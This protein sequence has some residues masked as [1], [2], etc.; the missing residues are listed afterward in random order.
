MRR[1]SFLD[2]SGPK[3][4]RAGDAGVKR[5]IGVRGRERPPGG[6]GPGSVMGGGGGRIRAG[7]R[8]PAATA[9]R[10][11]LLPAAFLILSAALLAGCAAAPYAHA[12]SRQLTVEISNGAFAATD[13]TSVPFGLEFGEAINASTLDASDINASSGTVRNLRFSPQYDAALGSPAPDGRAFQSPRNVAVDGSGNVYVVSAGISRVR[14]VDSA[15][16]H[17]ADLPG[18]FGRPYDVAVDRTSGTAYVTDTGDHR[19]MAFDSA[20]RHVADLPGPF[21][22]PAGVAV[23]GS[24]RI[25]VANIGNSTVQV[26][27]STLRH[28]ADLPGP[29]DRPHGVAVDGSGR[30]YVVDT[31]SSTVLIFDPALRRVADLPGPFYTPLSVA[32]DGSGRIYVAENGNSS[33][34]IRIYDPALRHIVDIGGPFSGATGVAVDGSSGAV[35]VAD[36]SASVHVFDAAY[37]F[38]VADPARGQALEVS[39]PAGRVRDA[40]GNANVASDAAVAYAGDAGPAPE[41]TSAQPGRTSAATI[42]FRVEFEEGVAGFGAGDVALSGTAAHGGAAD[43]A[44]SGASY[45]F[46]VSPASDGTIHVDIPAGA[47]RDAA[48]RHSGAATRL[49]V[50]YD[51]TPPAPAIA[52]TQPGPTSPQVVPFGLEFGEAINASTLDA[53]D[54]N[55]SSGTVRNLRFSPQY[56]A[57]LGSPAPDGRAFQSPRNVAV[58]GSGNVYVVSA[59]IS[60]VR[61]VD[62]AGDHVA[63]LPGPFGRPYDV[64][65][66][67]T[68]G[69]AYVTDTGDHRVMAFDS[70]GRHVADLPGPFNAPAGVAVDGSGRIYVANIGNSTVQVFNSTL[71]HVA[72]LPGPLD[73]PHGVAVDG[74]GRIYV[75]DTGSST[76]L[77]F[78]PALRRVADLPGPFYTPLSVA[79]DGSGRIYVAENGNSSGRIRIYDPA[80]R[81]IVDIGG[82]FSGATGV[83]VDGSSGAVYVADDSASVHVFDAAYEFEVADPARGQALEVSMPAGR[84]RDAAG[85]ANVAS[86]AA[87]AYAG[88][89]GPAPEV[90]SAQP[91]RTSAATISFRVEFEEGVAGFGAGDVAL[92]GTAAHGGAADFAGSGASYTFDVS[93]ASD[94][95]IHVDIPAGAARDAAGRHSGAATRLSVVYDGT[96]PAPAIAPTQP[97]PTSPQVVPFGLEFGEAINASTLDASDINASSGTVRNLRFSPQYDAALGSPAPDGRAFQSPRNVAVDGSGNVYVVSA[98]IS[99]VRIVDSAGDHVAD[100]P[101]PFGRPYDVAVDRT[102]GTAYVTDT[103]DHRVMAFDS[104]GRHVADL[105][106]PFNAPAGVA[107]DGSGRIYVANIGNSTVQVFNST[108]RHVADLPGPLD[109]P[110]GVAVDGSGRIY[111]VDTGS[112]TVLIFDPALRRVADLPG[113]FYTPLSVAVDGSGRIYVAENGNSSGR[114]RIYD[115]ALRHIVDIGGPFSGATGVAVD[116]SSGA[117]YVADDSASVHVFDAAYEFEVADPARGQALEVSMPAGRVR[118]AAGNANVASDAAVAYAGDAGPAPEVTSAQPGRTSAATISFRVEF[119]EGVAGFGAGDVALSGTAAHGGAADFAGSGASYTFD[120]SPAS[121]GTIH[122]DIPAG[123][124]RD[125]AGRHSGAAT[126]LSVVYD[127]T[128]PTPI[129]VAENG[130]ATA[131]RSSAAHDGTGPTPTVAAAQPDPTNAATIIFTVEFSGNVTGFGVGDVVL[132][133]TALRG[134]ATEFAGGGASYSFEVSPVYDGTILVDIPAGAARDADGSN[135]TAAKQFSITYDGTPPVPAID[136][137]LPGPSGLPAVPFAVEFGEPVNASTFAASDIAASSGEVRNLRFYPRHNATL[138]SSGSGDGQFDGT[139]GIAVDGAGRMYV[140][141]AG[142]HRVQVFDPSGEHAATIGSPGSGDGQFDGPGGIAVDGTTGTVYVADTGNDRIQMFDSSLEHAATVGGSGPGDGQFDGPG[143][144]AVDG[145][146]GTVYVAD[147]G[148]DRIQMFDSSLEHAATVGGSGPGDGQFDGPGGIAVDGT[149][150]TVYVADTGNDRIQMF[151]SSLEHAAT[152]GGSGPGDGQFDGPGGIAVDGAGN[153]YVADRNN[154]RV[155]AFD[156]PRDHAATVAAHPGRPSA[157]VSIPEGTSIS[158]C[159]ETGECFV[160]ANVTIDAGGAVTWSNDDISAHTVTGGNTSGGPDGEF[161]SGLFMPDSAFSHTFEEAGEYA[162]YCIIHPWAAGTVTV[163]VGGTGG[164]AADGETG[165]LDHAATFG[166]PGSGGGQF[167]GPGGIAVGGSTGTVYVADT[168]NDRV[169]V[170]DPAYAFDVESPADGQNLTTSLPAGLVLD[171]AGNANEASNTAGIGIDRTWPAATIAAAQPD[172]TNASTIGFTVEF[173]ENVTGFGAEGVALSGTAPRGNATNFAGSGASYSFEVSPTGDGTILVS[174]PANAARDEAGNGNEAERFSIAYD[175]TPPVPA[176][177]PALPGPAYPRAATFAVRFGEPVNASTFEASDIDASPGTARNLRFAP[178]HGA[179]LGSSGDGGGQFDGTSGVAVDGSG[180]I[181]VADAGNHRVQVFGL[182]LDHAAAFGSFGDGDGQFDG[183]EGVAVDGSASTVYVADTGNHRVQVFGP[184]LD[185]AAAFGS[186]GDGDGQFDGPEG[187]AVDGSAGTVYVADTGN[188]RVQVFGPSLDHAAA[189]GSFGDGDGQFDGPEGVAVDGSGRIYVAD[190]GNHRVQVFDSSLEHVATIGSRG[191]GDGQFDGPEGVAVDGAGNVYV[192]DTGNHR[193]QVFNSSL[194]RIAAYNAAHPPRPSAAVSIAEGASIS[195]CAE[196]GECLVPANVTVDAGGAVTWSNDD[197]AAHTVT[198]GSTSGGPDGEFDSS[199]FM[200][201]SAFSHTFEEAGEYTYYCIIHPWA[202]GTVTVVDRGGAEARDLDHAA[203]FGSPGSGGGQFNGPEGVAVDGAGNAYVADTGNDRVQVFDPAYSFDVVN[204]AGARNFAVSMPAGRVLDAAGNANVASNIAGIG[205]NMT[206]PTPV[207]KAAQPD[208]TNATTIRFDVEFGENVTGFGAGDV[209]VSGTANHSGAENF[210]GAGASYSFGVSPGSDGTILVDIPAG[211]ARDADGRNSPAA[212]RFSITYDGT[213]PVPAIAPAPPAEAYVCHYCGRAAPPVQA[214]APALQGAAGLPAVPFTVEFSEPVNAS[215][216]EASDIDVYPGTARNLR[217]APH[218][219]AASGS[220]GSGDG[221]FN[222]P[223][224]IAVDGSGNVYV[225]DTHND[226]VLVLNSSLDHVATLHPG[227]GEGRFYQPKGVAVD[228][229]GRIYVADRSNNRILVFNSSLDHAAT[230]GSFGTGDGQFANP[231]GVAVDGSGRIYVA[232]TGNDR[233]Q[234]FDSSLA[235]VATVGSF[236]TGDGRFYQPKGIAVD[237]SGRI[238]VADTGNHRVQVLNSSLDHA[239]SAGSFG[240]GDGQFNQP[241]GIAVDGS[242]RIYV[243]DTGNDRVQVLNSSL[244]RV[245]TLHPG[246]IYVTYH[247]PKGIAV[248]GT[249]GK[250]FVADWGSPIQVFDPAYSFDVVNPAGARN[251]AVSMPAGRVLDA[252]GNANVASNIAGIGTNMTGPTPVVKAAQPD[253]T[254]ATTIRFDVEFGENVTGFGAGDV[255]VSGTAN[256]SGAENFA[257]AGA[258]YSFGVSPG[259][260]G[261]ILVDIPAGAARDADGRN[262]PAAERFS[263]TYDGTPPV[264]AIAPAPPAEAYVCHYCGRAAPPVQAIAPAL[265]G[266]AGLPAVPFTVEFSEPV[267]ASTFEASDIDVY[268]GTAR[269]LRF[270]PH[271]AAASGSHGSGDGQF[272]GPESIAVDGSGNVYVA[273]THNDRV[274]VLNSSLD[275]VATLHPGSGEGRFYQPKGVAVD[276]SGRIYVADRSNNRI[277]VF[278]SSLD[279]AATVGSFGT[280]DGQFANPEGVAVDGSGRI[281]VADTGNDR[282]QVFDSSLAHVATVGSFG[283]GDGRFYQPKGIAVDGSGRIYVADTGNHRVQVLN[284]SLDHASS[285]GSFGTGD[286]QFN[287]PKGI[288]VDGSGRIYV[289]DTGNDRVQVLN[290]SLDRVATLHPGSIYVT[291]HTPKGIAVDGTT[292]KIFV[293]DWGSP[294]QVF[295]PAYSFDVVNPAGAR[296]FAVSMPAGRV[297][298]AAGN[299]NVAS[300]IAGIG[301]NMTGPTPVVKAAQPDPTNATTIRFDVEFGENVTGFG[302]GDVAVSGTANHSGAENFAGAGASYSFGVSPGSDGTILVD[303][304]AGAARDADGRNSPAA[305]RFSITYDGT[306]PVPAIAPAPPAE[307]YVCHYCGRAAPPVQAIAPALQGAAG[308][309]AVPFTV[310]FSE[311]VNASTFEASDIDVYPGTAR[312]LRFAPHHAAASGSHGSGDGQFNG[313]ESIAVDGSGNVYVA[314]THNDRV[315]VLNSSL[316]HVATL[317][318]GSGEGRFYQ[319]KGVAVDGSGRIY[320]AD[321]SNNR[322]LVFNSSLDH[323]ATVGSF[324]TG[325]GQFANPEGVAVDGSGRIYVADTGNDRVQVFDSSLAHVA[326]VG[327]F[328]TGDGRFYQPKGIAVDGSGRIYVADTG[329]HRVQVLNSSL[330][331]A[332]SAGSFGTGDGQFNQPKGIAVDGSGRIYVADTGN[333]RVQVL[334]SS[335]DRVATLHPG[336]IYVTYHTPKGIAVDGT[337]GKIFVADWGSP[338]QVFDPAYSFDVVNPA[339]ARNFAVSMPAG[340]VLDAAGNANVASNIAGIGTNMT[341]PTPVVKAAQPDPT[342]ATTIRFDVE[343]GENVTGFGAGDVAVSGTANHSGAENFAGAGASYSFGVSPGSDGTILVDIPAGA[344]RDA[345]GRNSPAAERFSITYDGTPP[346]PAIAPAPPGPADLWTVSFAVQFGEPI[347]ASTLDA[348]DIDAYPGTVRNLRFAPQHDAGFGSP[349]GGDGQLAWPNGIAVDDSGNVYVADRDNHRVQVFNSSLDHASTVGFF[350]SGDGQFDRPEGVAVDGSGNV[351]VADT[352]NDRVQVF[353]FSLDHAA[354][355]GSSGSGGGQFSSPSGIAVDGSGRLYVADTGNHRVQVFD[356]S[357]EH[358]AT[359]GSRGPGDGQFNRPSGVAVD[360]SGNVYVADRNNHRVQ[361][362]DSSLDHMATVGSYAGRGQGDGQFSRPSGVAVD[363]AGNVYV[364]DASNRRV[365]VFNS[366]LDHMATVNAS[367]DG[368]FGYVDGVA[369]DGSGRMYVADSGNYRVH[370]FD[371]AYAFDVESP[372]GARNLTVSMQAGRVLDAAGNANEAS[373]AASIGA[374][375]T[376]P[377]PTIATAQASPTSAASIGFAVEFEENVTG[378][379]AGDVTL[380]GTASHG[381]IS[382]FAGGGASYSFAVSPTGDGTILVDIP[383]GAAWYG[384]GNA[385][386]AAERFSITYD[387]TPPV[388]AIAPALPGPADLRT[389]PFIVEFGEPINASTLDA[390]DISA[391]SG[392]VRNLRFAPQHDAAFGASGS[393]DGQLAWPNGIAVDGAG[394]MFV[395]DRDNHRVQVFDP[396]GDHTSTVGAFGSGDGQFDRPEGVAV[397]GSGNVYVADT[398]NDRVQVF[399]SSLDHAA[400]VGSPGSGGGLFSSPSGVAVDGSGNVYVADTGNHRVQVFSS[401]EHVATVGSRGPGDGQ[402]NRP[403]GVAVD[404]SGNVYVADRNNH[405]VQVFDS[406]LEHVA[407][408]GSYAGRGQGDGQFSRPSGVAVDVAGNVYVADA[409]NRRVQVFNSSLDHAATVNAS[410]GGGR[411]GYTEGVAVDGSGRMYVADSGNDRVHAFDAAYAFDVESPAGARNLTVSVP[412]GRVLDAAGNANEASNAASIGANR[413]GPAPII[414]AEQSSPTNAATIGFTVEFGAGVTGFGAGDAVL[415]GTAKHGGV[416]NFAA[417]NASAY[418]FGISPISDGTVLVDIPEGAARDV[419]GNPSAEAERFSITYDGT[420]PVPAITSAQAGPTNAATIGF[421]V[422]FGENVTGFAPGDVAASGTAS[423]G[424]AAGFA[425]AGASYSFDV[426]PESDGTV[427]VDIP[428][429]AARDAAGNPSAAAERFSIEY[430]GTPPV[431]AIESAQPDPTGAP[432]IG[433]AVKFGENVTGFGA[434]DL[435]IHGTA[436]HGGAE[437][438]AGAGASYS[439]D[440]SPE[441]DGTVLVDIPAGAARDVAGNPSAEAERFS[442]RY[443]AKLPSA[444]V[445]TV[446]AAQPDPTNSATINFQVNFSEPVTGF[447]QGNIALSGTAAHGGIANF[448]GAGASYSFDVLPESDGTILVDV[449]AGMAKG[450]TGISSAAAERFSIEYDGTAPAVAYAAITGPNQITVRYTEPAGAASAYELAHVGGA[451]RKVTDVRGSGTD[452]HTVEFSGAA[453]ARNATGA[454]AVNRT[455]VADPAGNALEPGEV[456]RAPAGGRDG[457]FFVYSVGD[458]YPQALADGQGPSLA[459][460][461][462]DLAAGEN[463]RLA[464]EFDEAAAAPDAHSFGGAVEIRG[465]GGITRLRAA[466]FQSVASGHDGDREFALDLS[467]AARVRLNAADL[468]SATVSL[469]AGFVSDLRGNAHAG[470]DPPAAPLEYAQD[471]TPPRLVRATVNLAPGSGMLTLVFDEAATAPDPQQP[472]G[473][474]E[475]RG[476]AAAVALSAGDVAS[477]AHGRTGDRAFGLLLTDAKRAALGEAGLAG[478]AHATVSLPAGFVSN[479][480]SGS[481]P[482]PA[483]LEAGRDTAAPSFARAFVSGNDSFTA[484]YTEPVLTVPAHYTGI[485]VDGVAAEG[486]RG[487][488][489]GVAAFGSSV[490]I[491]W[492]AGAGTAASAGSVVEFGLSGNVTDAFGNPLDNPGP[493]SAGG[494]AAGKRHVQL[495]VFS[496]GPGDP[497][498]EAARLGAEAFNALSEDRGYPFLLSVSEYEVPAG[499]PGGA[500]EAALRGAHDGGR[501]PVLYVGPASDAALGGMAGYAAANGVVMISHSSAARSL[502]VEG[503]G[504]YRLEPGEAHAARVLAHMIARGGIDAV[505]PVVQEGLHGPGYGLLGPLESDLVPFGIPVG[506]PVEF[507][508]GGSAAESVGAAVAGAAGNGSVAVVY[509]GSDSEFVALAGSAPAGGRMREAAWFAAGGAGAGAGAGVAASPLVA[510]DAAAAQFARDTRLSAVQFAVEGNAMTDYIDRVSRGAPP[511]SSTPAYAAY[512]AAR[513]LGGALALAGGDPSGAGARVVEAAALDGGPLGRIALDGNGD[514]RL[515]VTYGVWSVSGAPAGWERAPELLRGMDRCGMALEKSALALPS[516]AP[517]RASGQARQTVTNTGTVP[518]PAVSVSATDWTLRGLDGSPSGATLPFSL[519]E[520]SVD[521]AG[522]APLAAGAAIRAG[523]PAGGSVGVDFRL[524]L[525]GVQELDA[526]YVAQTITYG[527]NC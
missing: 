274:L 399:D 225:A 307:A 166:S 18:P 293:A 129:I 54:I 90:T 378:F 475:I 371:A 429:G 288:A 344:A 432:A 515:P 263:I 179:T 122:V 509:V 469:P 62:S 253:P 16:D 522:F 310:E 438:F 154:H 159:E 46:D 506:R 134:N 482:A 20:G 156:S 236:G 99:R 51:G 324:G 141:D 342:N 362:F 251:F 402:F 500:A 227:S 207:V 147:T 125:A 38:E 255:A 186:F 265:Q 470:G 490:V 398:G 6:C 163:S 135:S 241:K 52:P 5:G 102:S 91:G 13:P 53:S 210:A 387:G 361:V 85:N 164:A 299:A 340:R 302:A 103:G 41:V 316:D 306:P 48:G 204:P 152:V 235:H 287:Q 367:A 58:D 389:V 196:T 364:A 9:S 395:T 486:N 208:P 83:A 267:N 176:I 433:F 352:G 109:R 188:H 70:A 452:T 363:V 374:G 401:L 185:H 86:D 382:G 326:T 45:T 519:T 239:S 238:Y 305:E 193:V 365:Q 406:S 7:G 93:P 451:A 510:S 27:N 516:L 409:S 82:P 303:I 441:S 366:S 22:A 88:D 417:A 21:N 503:D 271:H 491:S 142:N 507:S 67:R 168:G 440:V 350:G 8:G 148:N 296:N 158:G 268:P 149:T 50:V 130:S 527:I 61:I 10:R 317:H 394:R 34:R 75:V 277:L 205:T 181:Y 31:G 419:A 412:A 328:G 481:A 171:A 95:T 421:A 436:S 215:T 138:G 254:N 137:A 26:F 339:G 270:A 100:L 172:P 396:S 242:G 418:S 346:V 187:V 42:S 471:P 65:V 111:V 349:G 320:V 237:G 123:A 29:L 380:S 23:D 457:S 139:S 140:A 426:S 445:P 330:D 19:V 373:N 397:D 443:D 521:S 338:I 110:H 1:P 448:S 404:G 113:P 300:N 80:L 162:Y 281:Y 450:A 115:P 96:P 199:L 351:Y 231:E 315:L 476:P 17:V 243:A 14:I 258:S 453:A 106:G 220:H 357:L 442:I 496:R 473:D 57:A 218:H 240:T 391:S 246:S 101:G 182:S 108:L 334:N 462:L 501:G 415:S 195:G 112:S 59:G 424:G 25:Y 72:D 483:P 279:H 348:S 275:H 107:V 444:A 325:D 144:I 514:L 234:V 78:D 206:G 410:A 150:G 105:P 464:L 244:D 411:F 194:D 94:G 217:F 133:G 191:P 200:P 311:P 283:T 229:S 513:I 98:G 400:T 437:N 392:V 223:E 385:S 74:S 201:D 375:G 341:G 286:G 497:S 282:V 247:T 297:L 79:V 116:G 232:D 160:P 157:A 190:T 428:Q 472:S 260:D 523:T 379:V 24:G 435:K 467:G 226:R 143:G 175:G 312:N 414:T 203:T 63:D 214:I 81:H 167:D 518:M 126:R 318:P 420:P 343:F 252:A 228:G 84:V 524:D 211:A 161:D 248:D 422:E 314:D 384:A 261:T 43:F 439:F 360:G 189:F 120:V 295:D 266:A 30:I 222:G 447:R 273:D 458:V 249:T 335:L 230:V 309:P 184:S 118:D 390:S 264:P 488:A 407:T 289:A 485:T 145:T 221:Q 69:T 47:A 4:G 40:A 353:D 151:D 463:G 28:V 416:E 259:S 333:D 39:M 165:A 2:A 369:V 146:T 298:D 479:G 192:A 466:D 355:V 358:V 219:A 290:S 449:P 169:Q 381:G 386:A 455:A 493:K 512:E 136:P 33:G 393:G 372:A 11:R 323:A 272:N 49:S 68:S 494:Q 456:P 209:A 434:E 12:D 104:A 124:A 294:I 502:A 477:V 177:A 489:S 517:G 213:P 354:T 183:P 492:N 278:N 337:T 301:T 15:G 495:G 127:G 60:R 313:P 32:V 97:G 484:V 202:A 336:S 284:S 132:S 446:E 71:R 262:S 153:V 329:N 454:L 73:R 356:S 121:D 520:M 212:E 119:E 427:L 376:G 114:I 525:T 128:G 430:D 478:L 35:Y 198:S 89:A 292:G 345:D 66:D 423:H 461:R 405:R 465:A 37:E 408:V 308:L 44:G 383:A 498:A 174:I 332:S 474:I 256:H 291:Y 468:G 233:V 55:A 36:D 505:V 224:S 178:R 180:R 425:G 197:T 245:A 504:I 257:G 359:V 250:I 459:G 304:P 285:A 487:G 511:G 77:I 327:S 499:A 377:A 64:A 368:Q 131:E 388:P 173:S 155:Q 276:G 331:H 322:I 508:D 526:A 319:P 413:T 480:R 170:F 92:S 117:V 403:S 269:N 460:A 431:P 87:V 216:F 280:G 321:R 76:V 347:N 3:N 370:A 56:D